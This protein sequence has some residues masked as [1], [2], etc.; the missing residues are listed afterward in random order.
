MKRL[1]SSSLGADSDDEVGSLLQL[2]VQLGE[3]QGSHWDKH[4]QLSTVLCA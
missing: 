1:C 2:A 3:T 4:M